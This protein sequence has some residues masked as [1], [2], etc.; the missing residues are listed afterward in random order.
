MVIYLR[1][2]GSPLKNDP[3]SF[4]LYNLIFLKSLSI[5]ENSHCLKNESLSIGN[6]RCYNTN[7]IS[8]GKNS[9]T[10]KGQL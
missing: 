9:K 7:S 3:K 6:S 10:K 4:F 1:V 5:G 8:L 2:L